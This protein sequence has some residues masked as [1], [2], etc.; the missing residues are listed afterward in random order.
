MNNILVV[1]AHADDEALGCGIAIQQHIQNG[2]SVKVL[3]MIHEHE[4]YD[5]STQLL[6]DIHQSQ[7]ILGYDGL[8]ILR[9]P[10][11]SLDTIRLTKLAQEIEKVLDE[12]AIDIVYTHHYNDIN[13]DHRLTYEA[14]ITACRPTPSCNVKE[15]YGCW[16]PSSSE[17]M[18]YDNNSFKPNYIIEATEEQLNQK[19]KAMQAY[20]SE[21]RQPPHPRSER[22]IRTTAEA[23]GLQFGVNFAEAFQQYYRRRPLT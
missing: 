19:I 10:D 9:Y 7:K 5:D 8:R 6:N 16:I 13:K 18:P 3:M 15:L 21:I 17:W 2:D 20:K 1:T 22:G 4:R 12:D 23:F 11:Q 14:T